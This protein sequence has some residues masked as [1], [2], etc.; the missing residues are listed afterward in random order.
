MKRRTAI[1]VAGLGLVLGGCHKQPAAP[2]HADKAPV[3]A[4]PGSVSAQPAAPK[5]GVTPPPA[6][7]FIT[8]NAE[9]APAQNVAGD[10][11]PFLTKQLK[12]FIQQKGRM[13]QSF[14]ELAAVR[15]DS[16][17]RAPEGRKWVIDTA[18]VQVKAVKAQ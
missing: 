9:N 4:E 8:A 5:P 15:L 17:P 12:I 14:A 11:N 6:P 10:V 13:P 2:P 7:R 1:L 3:T 16:I 18:T